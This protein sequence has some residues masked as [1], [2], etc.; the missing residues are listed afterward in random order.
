MKASSLLQIALNRKTLLRAIAGEVLQE[1]TEGLKGQLNPP[2][3]ATF[4]LDAG[5]E[6]GLKDRK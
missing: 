4:I 3:E 1:V 6:R 2:T 5:E